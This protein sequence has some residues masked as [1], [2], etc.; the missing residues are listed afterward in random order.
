MKKLTQ[1]DVMK[2]L[3]ENFP[4]CVV[5]I[6]MASNSGNI[7]G[8]VA[9][10]KFDNMHYEERQ[11]V[12]ERVFDPVCIGNVGPIVCVTHTEYEMMQLDC[13]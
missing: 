13:F 3:K 1:N 2:I 12:L 5:D 10:E 8:T 6:E 4:D 9:S 7:I 11:L